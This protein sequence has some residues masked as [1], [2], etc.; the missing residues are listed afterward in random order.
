MQ[1]ELQMFCEFPKVDAAI[2]TPVLTIEEQVLLSAKPS[3]AGQ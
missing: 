3:L 2:R 1:L